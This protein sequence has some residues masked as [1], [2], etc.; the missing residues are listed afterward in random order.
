MNTDCETF[1]RNWF[2]DLGC[3]QRVLD[4]LDVKGSRPQRL[5]DTQEQRIAKLTASRDWHK[6]CSLVLA[7]ISA[8]APLASIRAAASAHRNADSPAEILLAAFWAAQS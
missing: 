3:D 2:C 7:E 4:W 1:A 5:S 6:A 8:R